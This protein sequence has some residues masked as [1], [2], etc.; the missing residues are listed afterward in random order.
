L[1]QVAYFCMEYGLGEALPLYAGG[2]GILAGD[3]LKAASDLC[4]PVVAVGLLFD[5]GYFR[6]TLDANGWQQELYPSCDTSS[7]PISTVVSASGDW[8]QVAVELPGRSLLLRLGQVQIG[9]VSL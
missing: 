4:V 6:Q 7:L 5:Q 9:N 2:L 1:Q 3:Y 8:R